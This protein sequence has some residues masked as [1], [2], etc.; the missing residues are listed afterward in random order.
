MLCFALIAH[1]WQILG[2]FPHIPLTPV[3]T[4]SPL[5][6][7]VLTYLILA[8][9][10]TSLV[11]PLFTILPRSPPYTAYTLLC[12]LTPLARYPPH[13]PQLA[14]ETFFFEKIESSNIISNNKIVMIFRRQPRSGFEGRRGVLTLVSCVIDRNND[15]RFNLRDIW[16]CSLV[17]TG[18]FLILP[19][20][21]K[22]TEK[23]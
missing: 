5:L 14:R 21:V 18:A 11:S 7:A 13:H 10:D 8:D 16:C 20:V 15:F 1:R 4:A 2:C 22:S 6:L 3:D 9:T 12:P 17:L 19:G 23:V